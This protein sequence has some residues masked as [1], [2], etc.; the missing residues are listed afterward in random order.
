MQILR[1][2]AALALLASLAAGSWA[3]AQI[4]EKW[5]KGVWAASL[6]IY[7]SDCK[8]LSQVDRHKAM[9]LL[10]EIGGQENLFTPYLFVQAQSNK[11]GQAWCEEVRQRYLSR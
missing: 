1:K 2:T 7:N 3:E 8:K 5:D 9:S 6:F 10:E 11:R 4:S